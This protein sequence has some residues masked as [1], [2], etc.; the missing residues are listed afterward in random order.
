VTY[1]NVLSLQFPV[2]TEKNHEN[3]SQCNGSPG[4]DLNPGLTNTKE[5]Y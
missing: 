2:E 5:E 1:F 3:L 4:Q